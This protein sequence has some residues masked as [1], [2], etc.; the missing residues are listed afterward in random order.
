[1]ETIFQVIVAWLFYDTYL[2]LHNNPLQY[3]NT[4]IITKI[5]HFFHEWLSIS[6]N[7]WISHN[8]KK[9][10]FHKCLLNLFL[11]HLG[12]IDN[13]HDILFFILFILYK[14]C[15][16]KASFSN[17]INFSI[18]LHFLMIFKVIPL[19]LY[20]KKFYFFYLLIKFLIFYNV[21]SFIDFLIKEA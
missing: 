14:N 15:I 6:N 11:I 16:A 21:L 9:M 5:L 10:N 13:F 8:F 4:W 20:Y 7:I 18:F 17:N 2:R 12:Y 19:I 1:M 3:I